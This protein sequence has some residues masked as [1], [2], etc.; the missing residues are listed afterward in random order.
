M[1]YLCVYYGASVCSKADAAALAVA[2]L[3]AESGRRF[4]DDHALR[5]AIGQ[6]DFL[7]R[8]YPGSRYRF[9]ALFAIGEIYKDDLNNPVRARVAFQEFLRQY[10]HHHLAEEARQAMAEPVRQAATRSQEDKDTN[11]SEQSSK[12]EPAENKKDAG[13]A[14]PEKVE[15]NEPADTNP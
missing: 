2:D 10:P 12:T 13:S 8:E 11:D 6:Y 7:R 1:A 4:N 3:L 15:G 14:N 5:S 9:E